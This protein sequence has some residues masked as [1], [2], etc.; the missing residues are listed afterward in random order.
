MCIL[1]LVLI[2]RVL[3]IHGRVVEAGDRSE[4]NTAVPNEV[5]LDSALDTV[6]RINAPHFDGDVRFSETAILW[7]GRV[8]LFENSADARVGY[9]DDTLYVRVGA[10]DRR[11]WYDISPSPVDL[12]DWDAVSLYLDLDGNIGNA[13]DANAYRLDAQLVW[14][15][16]R[17]PYQ[18]AYVGDGADWVAATLPYTTTSFWRGNAPNDSADDR[19][20]AL[21]YSIPFGSLDMDGPPAEGTKWGMAVMLHDRDDAGGTLAIPDQVWPEAMEPEQPATWGQLAFGM[22]TYRPQ[23]AIPEGTLTVRHGLDGA[24]VRDGDVGGSSVCGADAYPGYFDIWGDLNYAGKVFANIQNLSDISD[25]PCFSR[26]YVTFPLDSLPEERVILS[27]TLTLYQFGN[28]GEGEDP[29]PQPSLIQVHTVDRGWDENTLTWNNSPLALEN[30]ASA[31]ADVFPESPGEPREWDVS[32]A[33][34]GAYAA[35]TPLRLALYESDWHYHS[36]KYFWTSDITD[37]EAQM[38]PTLTVT[39]GRALAEI[40]KSAV[41]AFGDQGSPLTYTLSLLGSG[42]ELV[43]TDTLPSGVSPPEDIAWEGTDEEPTYNEGQHAITWTDLPAV[44]HQVIIRYSVRVD[45]GDTAVLTNTASLQEAGGDL[46][47][48]TATVIANPLLVFL[49][50]VLRNG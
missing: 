27:A 41:P 49:P 10:F 50:I 35:G 9:N 7:F 29:G 3:V 6:R 4:V 17:A 44:G 16:P 14:W 42:N 36:G 8:N 1:L 23:A 26:Y 48:D 33:V 5:E 21:A 25:W 34:A 45:T 37:Y 40:D 12:T 2:S 18:A 19:G 43:L 11:L 24:S 20:W 28:A 31:W 15:E 22:P 39:W 32:R 47:T 30:V 38:R 13:P 46:S